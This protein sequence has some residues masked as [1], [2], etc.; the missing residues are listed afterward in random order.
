MLPRNLECEDLA[1]AR[2][3]LEG[4][5]PAHR[6]RGHVGADAKAVVERDVT[7]RAF[8]LCRI[9]DGVGHKIAEV[10]LG[11]PCGLAAVALEC[12]EV[13][14]R[15]AHGAA[16]HVIDLPVD[17]CHQVCNLGVASVPRLYELGRNARGHRGGRGRTCRK[18]DLESSK[19]QE[20]APRLHDGHSLPVFVG[21]ALHIELVR[22]RVEH[23]VDAVRVRNEG[24]A[25]PDLGT[26]ALPQVREQ[27]HVIGRINAARLVNG[28]L[29]GL[30]ER[31][32]RGVDGKVVDKV[33]AL[34]F[35]VC[36]RAARGRRGHADIGHADLIRARGVFNDVVLLKNAGAGD[37]GKV[38]AGIGR[39]LGA[40]ERLERAHAVVELVVARHDHVVAAG[41]H[42]LGRE[43][44]FAQA[45]GGVALYDVAGVN[46]RHAVC[47]NLGAL[48]VGI[49]LERGI[50][51]LGHG[52]LERAVRVVG[53]EDDDLAGGV[54]AKRA[55]GGCE[56]N[57]D[58]C[59]HGS[60][61]C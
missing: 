7:R 9:K 26:P 29:H 4:R 31:L 15:Y 54:R 2:H 41:G 58:A 55:S 25:S 53:A 24:V 18:V 27:H 60:G 39:S 1:S 50:A 51:E 8:G 35:E 45:R 38:A 57:G 61:A 48:R 37:V 22:V 34:V 52:V 13:R 10:G 33:A 32:A 6:S 5:A 21:N 40:R 56:R 46:E 16:R 11:G 49:V 47:P 28:G 17:V 19:A 23:G 44:P 42:S 36:R 59:Q 30:V 3:R 12:H 14:F 20:L 43:R